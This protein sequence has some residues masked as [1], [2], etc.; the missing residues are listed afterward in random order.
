MLMAEF[1]SV[2]HY[3]LLSLILFNVLTEQRFYANVKSNNKDRNLLPVSAGQ[4]HHSQYKVKTMLLHDRYP[5]PLTQVTHI[6]PFLPHHTEV[7]HKPTL[8]QPHSFNKQ[9]NTAHRYSTLP[10]THKP[11]HALHHPTTTHHSPKNPTTDPSPETQSTTHTPHLRSRPQLQP[12]PLIS[13]PKP[14]SHTLPHF[15]LHT[16]LTLTHTPHNNPRSLTSPPPKPTHYIPLDTPTLPIIAHSRNP[17]ASLNT[18]NNS[19]TQLSHSHAQTP[20][21]LH[22]QTHLTHHTTHSSS[23]KAPV[24]TPQFG[25]SGTITHL[26][27]L[28]ISQS[29][30]TNFRFRLHYCIHYRPPHCSPTTI[31]PPNKPPHP[32]PMTL[33]LHHILPQFPHPP[34]PNHCLSPTSPTFVSLPT[35]L[36]THSGHSYSPT[37]LRLGSATPP[38]PYLPPPHANRHIHFPTLH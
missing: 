26:L 27:P 21:T 8:A 14:P 34:L 5:P 33:H 17:R 18:P 19:R 28:Y 32:E 15:I 37:P 7:H 3:T 25:T 30:P 1:S 36:P 24:P 22:F 13:P 35:I 4:T 38:T 11:T 23:H 16:Q 10:H 2:Q 31:P 9:L 12:A 6:P 29:P 20:P